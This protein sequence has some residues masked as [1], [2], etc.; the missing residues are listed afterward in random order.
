[1]AWPSLFF[2]KEKQSGINLNLYNLNT[3]IIICVY[4]IYVVRF[5]FKQTRTS[6]IWI[7]QRQIN[8][9][10]KKNKCELYQIGRAEQK[11]THIFCTCETVFLFF[12]HTASFLTY[13]CPKITY[14]SVVEINLLINRKLQYMHVRIEFQ[15]V[16]KN[17]D[18]IK[19]GVEL[20]KTE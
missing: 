20:A 18:F 1:M 5:N 19:I 2:K 12:F 14:I 17:L 4:I 16:E 3:K 6:K 13:F 15:F 10:T 9:Q 11:I 8:I 7:F